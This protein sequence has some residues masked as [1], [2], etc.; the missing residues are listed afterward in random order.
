[1]KLQTLDVVAAAVGIAGSA[2]LVHV[3][4]PHSLRGTVCAVMWA[5]L[6]LLVTGALAA[7][8]RR[9]DALL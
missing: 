3:M 2:V 7:G 9:L 8:R 5:A 4:H 6:V 1:M